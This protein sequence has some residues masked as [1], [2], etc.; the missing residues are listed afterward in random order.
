MSPYSGKITCLNE[1]Y[2]EHSCGSSSGSLCG[3]SVIARISP[4]PIILI[5]SVFFFVLREPPSAPSFLPAQARR[6]SANGVPPRGPSTSLVRKRFPLSIAS[7]R[8]RYFSKNRRQVRR[9]KRPPGPSFQSRPAGQPGFGEDR[10]GTA[11]SARSVIRRR[12]RG[13]PQT[14]SPCRRASRRS[15]RRPETPRLPARRGP[16]V[17]PTC[18]A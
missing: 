6:S 16:H 4:L 1:A 5:F 14:A 18:R 2:V 11:S 15:G 7:R 8:S 9:D 17:P 3:K 12:R 10:P 13:V